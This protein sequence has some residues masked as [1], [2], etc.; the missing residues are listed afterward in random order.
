MKN[1]VPLDTAQLHHAEFG[2]LIVRFFE[3]FSSSGL[4]QHADADFKRLFEALQHQIPAYHSTLNQMKANDECKNIAALDS[5]RDADLRALRDG[6]KPYK[7]AK[8]QAEKEAFAAIRLLMKE[9]KGI[10][11][12]SYT[13]ETDR[14]NSLVNKLL[15]SDYSPHVATLGIV[16]FINHLADSNTAFNELFSECSDRAFQ[17]QAYDVKALRKK[18]KE[19]YGTMVNYIA[20]LASVKDDAYY[21]DILRIINSG[22]SDFSNIVLERRQG[23]KN[24]VENV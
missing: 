4:D 22:R 3:D 19:V 16:K 5:D 11:D 1:L 10:E 13:E 6:L 8:T 24:N 7:N 21:K 23:I 17:Q 2:Q 20:A 15:S 12:R 9:Y 18:M 14:L